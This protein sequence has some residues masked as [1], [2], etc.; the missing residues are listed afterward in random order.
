MSLKKSI[1]LHRLDEKSDQRNRYESLIPQIRDKK[2]TVIKQSGQPDNLIDNQ[3]VQLS[4]MSKN[5][6]SDRKGRFKEN[7]LLQMNLKALRSKT[8]ENEAKIMELTIE[9]N[10]LLSEKRSYLI[11][12]D[13][14][15]KMLEKILSERDK[16]EKKIEMIMFNL[17]NVKKECMRKTSKTKL[18]TRRRIR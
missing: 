18:R 9:R 16:Q 4:D 17:D 13:L 14:S 10:G 5:S 8:K 6:V 12:S 1:S 2:I 7:D 3:N 11:E 15:S